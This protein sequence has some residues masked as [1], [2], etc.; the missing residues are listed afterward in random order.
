TI[1]FSAG[2]LESDRGSRALRLELS[3]LLVQRGPKRILAAL[4]LILYPL[5]L[6]AQ[7]EDALL[8]L[9][10]QLIEPVIGRRLFGVGRLARVGELLIQDGRPLGLEGFDSRLEDARGNALVGQSPLFGIQLV[11]ELRAQLG[12]PSLY[13]LIDARGEIVLLLVDG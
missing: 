2:F 7:V 6:L 4:R 13:L 11:L 1:E 5:A 10:S 8:I 3:R 9:P 12:L